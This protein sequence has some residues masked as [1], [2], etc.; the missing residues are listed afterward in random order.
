MGKR[1]VKRLR[2]TPKNAAVD[3]LERA[4]ENNPARRSQPVSFAHA[5][6]ALMVEQKRVNRSRLQRLRAAWEMAVDN[7]R[8]L[9]SAAKRAEIRSLAKTGEVQITVAGASLQHE[10]G[11]VYKQALLK[12]MRELLEGKD[13]ISGL[14]VKTKR[15][16]RRR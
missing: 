2:V 4:R 13:S 15:G 3:P 10:V 9:S 8:G 11:V 5:L 14:K 12:Q 6:N 7:V 1:L 16:G